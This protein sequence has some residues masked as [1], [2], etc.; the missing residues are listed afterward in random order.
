M[1]TLPLGAESQTGWTGP[2]EL[3]YLL[4]RVQTARSDIEALR[5]QARSLASNP[6]QVRLLE[7]LEN[8]VAAL[9]TRHL[10]VP[11]AIR[12][13]LQLQRCLVSRKTV[14][15]SSSRRRADQK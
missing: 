2:A 3:S 14:N 8:Y 5:S 4:H 13:E 11:P 6:E 9:Q 1:T 10:P 12:D 7:S 15:R